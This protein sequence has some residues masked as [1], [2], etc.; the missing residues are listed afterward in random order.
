MGTIVLYWDCPE[1]CSDS[2]TSSTSSTS[3]SSA[4]STSDASSSG[5]S[6]SGGGSGGC[7]Y[8][9]L[10]V[11]IHVTRDA[12]PTID[13]DALDTYVDGYV[14]SENF[15]VGNTV[16]NNDGLYWD[17]LCVISEILQAVC[18]STYMGYVNDW[19][20]I[21]ASEKWGMVW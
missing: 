20:E 3:D 17:C 15:A 6:S 8:Q 4:S 12:D 16:S 9:F 14:P 13:V 11:R 2:S 18:N 19:A 5:S 10:K 7:D 1:C 21:S